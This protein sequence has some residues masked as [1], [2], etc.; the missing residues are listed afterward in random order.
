MLIW[1]KNKNHV[2]IPKKISIHASAVQTLSR[3]PTCVWCGVVWCG[4][5][6]DPTSLR[7][8]GHEGEGAVEDAVEDGVLHLQLLWLRLLLPLPPGHHPGH[9]ARPAR[10]RH[11]AGLRVV[12]PVALLVVSWRGRHRDGM[13]GEEVSSAVA[14]AGS[15][16]SGRPSLR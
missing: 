2:I 9:A 10:P 16:V 1:L 14:S 5:C 8:G 15:Q 11:R 4:V 6:D 7:G 12:E 13:G 3:P